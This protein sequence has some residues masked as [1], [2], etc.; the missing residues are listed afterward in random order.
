[1]GREGRELQRVGGV[2][3]KGRD[4]KGSPN[5]RVIGQV[6][7]MSARE[8]MAGGRRA[9]TKLTSPTETS[10]RQA[11]E[12]KKRKETYLRPGIEG[13]RSSDKERRRSNEPRS[14]NEGGRSRD[15]RRTRNGFLG[16]PEGAALSFFG[17]GEEV[18]GFGEV[19]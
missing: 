18:Q 12:I 6:G 13:W 8:G 11:R 10:L 16:G 4:R 14:W 7:E 5:R 2:E 15:A 9:G 19:K 3:G 17:G 1:L